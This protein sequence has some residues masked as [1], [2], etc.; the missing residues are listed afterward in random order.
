MDQR[1]EVANAAAANEQDSESLYHSDDE[2]EA[3]ADSDLQGP[4]GSTSQQV[5]HRRW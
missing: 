4:L 3:G 1:P 2:Q 5:C